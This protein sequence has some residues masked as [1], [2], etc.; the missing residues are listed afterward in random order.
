MEWRVLLSFF[1]FVLYNE[2]EVAI[3]YSLIYAH[4]SPYLNKR[5]KSKGYALAF[6]LKK[7]EE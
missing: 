2:N 3:S 7:K 4:L 5:S 1:T 6:F